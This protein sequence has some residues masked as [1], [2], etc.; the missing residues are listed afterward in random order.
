MSEC[1]FDENDPLG[2]PF[3][4]YYPNETV[5]KTGRLAAISGL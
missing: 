5:I 4:Y 2:S 3:V 1:T